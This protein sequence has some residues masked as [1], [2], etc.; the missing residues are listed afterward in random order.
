MENC[1]SRSVVSLACL[2]GLAALCSVV[3]AYTQAQ[4]YAEAAAVGQSAGAEAKAGQPPDYRIISRGAAAGTYQAFPDACRAANGDI[5]A[6]FYA[7]YGHVSAPNPQWPKA[8]RI[9]MVR[10]SDEGRTWT[11]PAVLYDDD[12]DNRDRTSPS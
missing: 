10:S 3:G 1:P 4:N 11:K 8:G 6:V 2:A 7:G 9:C 5:I 12:G